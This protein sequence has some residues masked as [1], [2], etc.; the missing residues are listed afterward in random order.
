MSDAIQKAIDKLRTLDSVKILRT[1]TSAYD[2]NKKGLQDRIDLELYV[3]RFTIPC[4]IL[5]DNASDY[6][7]PA[8]L[9]IQKKLPDEF[10]QES[11]HFLPTQWDI[12]QEDCLYNWLKGISNH[13]ERHLTQPRQE[14]KGKIRKREEE[15][16]SKESFFKKR[17]LQ[18]EIPQKTKHPEPEPQ[19]SEEPKETDQKKNRK[20]FMLAWLSKFSEH[21]ICYDDQDYMSFSLYLTFEIE[22]EMWQKVMQKKSSQAAQYE[23]KVAKAKPLVPMIIQFRMEPSFPKGGLHLLFLSVANTKTPGSSVPDTHRIKCEVSQKLLDNPTCIISLLA[24]KAIK[25]HLDDGGYF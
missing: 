6:Q 20:S 21:I 16:E 19:K 25:F 1:A 11:D 12:R 3:D 24:K 18:K 9:I 4:Q 15:S 22:Q 7:F 23:L 14:R 2:Y 17:L 5:L 13:L 10:K 8:D